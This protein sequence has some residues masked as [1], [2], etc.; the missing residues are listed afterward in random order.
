LFSLYGKYFNLYNFSFKNLYLKILLIFSFLIPFSKIHLLPEELE[1]TAYSSISYR[2]NKN[3]IWYYNDEPVSFR[4]LAIS[5]LEEDRACERQRNLILKALA[6]AQPGARPSFYCLQRG[7]GLFDFGGGIAIWS[8]RRPIHLAVLPLSQYTSLNSCLNDLA[9]LEENGLDSPFDI[10]NR[11][12]GVICVKATG[13]MD[14]H[15][16]Y[17]ARAI[18]SSR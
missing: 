13:K 16:G 17:E 1:H 15:Q 9:R 10:F 12:V 3:F 6:I 7:A 5:G 8:G 11:V 2:K 18:E 4:T 14:S